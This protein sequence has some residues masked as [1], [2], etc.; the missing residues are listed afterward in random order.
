[1][2]N[3]GGAEATVFQGER[4]E[5]DD[6]YSP[7]VLKIDVELTELPY[8]P[9]VLPIESLSTESFVTRPRKV[10]SAAIIFDPSSQ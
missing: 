8:S 10:P 4:D 5:T 6:P 1:V 3:L 7:T 2:I 9:T